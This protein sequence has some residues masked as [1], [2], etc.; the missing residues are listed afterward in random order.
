MDLQVVILVRLICDIEIVHHVH[1]DAVERLW[2]ALLA[3]VVRD[4]MFERRQ[5][6]RGGEIRIDVEFAIEDSGVDAF[7]GV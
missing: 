3:D 4:V 1:A 7:R 2:R 6:L 5:R